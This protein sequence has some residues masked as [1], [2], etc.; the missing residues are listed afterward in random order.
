MEQGAVMNKL[1]KFFFSTQGQINKYQFNLGLCGLLTFTMMVAPILFDSIS[2]TLVFAFSQAGMIS[3]E[4]LAFSFLSSVSFWI[5]IS[6][7]Y[8]CVLVLMKKRFADLKVEKDIKALL[9]APFAHQTW[10][11]LYDRHIKT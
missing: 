5:A 11:M 4:A 10:S 8:Y 2:E 1:I 9:F 6:M 3:D 7:L